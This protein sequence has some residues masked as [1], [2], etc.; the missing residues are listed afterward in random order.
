MTTGRVDR[1][2][3]L[4]YIAPGLLEFHHVKGE[5]E[6]DLDRLGRLTLIVVH[7]DIRLQLQ[8]IADNLLAALAKRLH[9]MAVGRFRIV[10]VSP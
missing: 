4:R 6:R 8:A 7:I 10:Q 1:H 2:C 5:V 3:H 9:E